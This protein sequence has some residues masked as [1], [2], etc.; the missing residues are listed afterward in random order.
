MCEHCLYNKLCVPENKNGCTDYVDGRRYFKAEWLPGDEAFA[1]FGGNIYKANIIRVAVATSPE[2]LSNDIV[3]HVTYRL[4]IN[5]GMIERKWMSGSK[6][7]N[8]NKLY[9][10]YT[11]AEE[12]LKQ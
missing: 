8:E 12:A 7:F 9:R 10:W 3:E 2:Y 6:S 11:D 4:S 1:I 5:G